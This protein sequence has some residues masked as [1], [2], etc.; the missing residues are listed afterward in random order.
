MCTHHQQRHSSCSNHLQTPDRFQITERS[1]HEQNR[2][3]RCISNVTHDEDSLVARALQCAKQHIQLLVLHPL[4]HS[5]Q[6]LQGMRPDNQEPCKQ[7]QHA[8]RTLNALQLLSSRRLQTSCSDYS[9]SLTAP[10][11]CVED[12]RLGQRKDIHGTRAA[13]MEHAEHTSCG[14]TSLLT[15]DSANSRL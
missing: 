14:S 3:L 1:I 8:L 12:H 9:N 11:Q 13:L 2:M 10:A 7:P 4:S 15:T 5:H 6:S